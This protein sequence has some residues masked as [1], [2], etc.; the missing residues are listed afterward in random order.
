VAEN[1]RNHRPAHD[2]PNEREVR[3][4]ADRREDQRG[5]GHPGCRAHPEQLPNDERRV[6]RQHDEIA[7]G[8]VHD[9]HHAPD[10]RQ[11]RGEQRVDRA[12]EEPSDD[13]LDDGC[14]H[15]DETEG[16]ATGLN[17]CPHQPL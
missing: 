1:L 10:E 3:G 11:P 4:D 12:E 8:E 17:A 14:G 13:H 9:V 5:D 2:V 16:P 6:H 15:L 7:V